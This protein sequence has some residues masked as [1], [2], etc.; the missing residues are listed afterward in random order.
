MT[1]ELHDNEENSLV[2][3]IKNIDYDYQAE[4]VVQE[5]VP[6]HRRS[7]DC[8]P[9]ESRGQHLVRVVLVDDDGERARW[10]IKDGKTVLVVKSERFTGEWELGIGVPA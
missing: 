6:G 2:A 9:G 4:M 8:P 5:E 1:L 10:E 3:R 7:Y